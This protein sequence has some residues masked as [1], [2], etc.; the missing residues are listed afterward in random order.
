MSSR[1]SLR[2]SRLRT[3]KIL[4]KT[5]N[6]EN[7]IDILWDKIDDLQKTA[8]SIQNL[9]LK[10]EGKNKKQKIKLQIEAKLKPDEDDSS[11]PLLLSKEYGDILNL[12]DFENITS[13]KD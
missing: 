3:N 10:S 13:K 7:S 6:I 5:I 9:L 12:E 2:K 11:K 8:T 4:F 1:N